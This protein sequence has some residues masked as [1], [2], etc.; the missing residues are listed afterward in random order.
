MGKTLCI[1][2]ARL[3]STRLPEKINKLINN[4]TILE[5]VYYAAKKSKFTDFIRIAIPSKDYDKITFQY[6]EKKDIFYCYDGNE[7][8]LI[9]RYYHCFK[10]FE[11][12]NYEEIKT[13]VRLTSDCPLLFYFDKIIDELITSHI[14][15]G[16][17]Y[18]WNRS[19][20]MPSGL[21]VEVFKSN[22]LSEI[23]QLSKEKNSIITENEKEHCTLYIRNNISN[24]SIN[25]QRVFEF[26]LS[27]ME[28]AYVS[29]IIK[30][31]LSIDTEKDFE[32]VS[33]IMTLFLLKEMFEERNKN[34]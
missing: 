20:F 12:N 18:S 22:I 14:N 3:G 31:K 27:S 25:H 16:F 32:K 2:Q 24:Y 4:K 6:K 23:Y 1:I 30:T 33:D 8:D 26:N 28:K 15:T 11:K 19:L 10:S 13:I 29:G 17:D 7:D 9:S 5:Y 21:D 34:S